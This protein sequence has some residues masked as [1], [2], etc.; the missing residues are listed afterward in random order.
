MDI[1][2][3]IKEIRSRKHITQKDLASKC[4]ISANALCSIEKNTSFPS[5]ET[6]KKI[7]NKI[8]KFYDSIY[9]EKT[10]KSI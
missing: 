3:A 9:K 1:G 10:S 6:I 7:S 4:N 8:I 5:K 2:T